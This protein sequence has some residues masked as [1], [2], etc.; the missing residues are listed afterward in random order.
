MWDFGDGGNSNSANPSHTYSVSGT[1]TVKLVVIY[2]NST[3]EVSKQIVI[4]Q[5]N[6]VGLTADRNYICRPG[7]ITFTATGKNQAN[8]TWDFGDG[9]SSGSG[10]NPA[11]HSY[12]NFGTYT[13]SLN[14]TDIWGCTASAN[15]VID[16]K[17]PDVSG[18]V[19]ATSGCIPY[20]TS[21]TANATIPVNSTVATYAWDFGDGNTSATTVNS[22]NHT[23]TVRGS[24]TPQLT[25]TTSEG[26]TANFI[27]PNVAFGTAPSSI[28]AYPVNDS[29]CAS[30][31]AVLIAKSPNANM[32]IWQF[33]DGTTASTGDTLISHKY[34]SLGPKTITVR[35]YD[36]GCGSAPSSFNV[37]VIGVIAEYSYNINCSSRSKVYFTNNST[38]NI[39]SFLW[40]YGDGQQND[41][42]SSPIH[43]FPITGSYN[44]SLR[45][46]DSLSGCSDITQTSIYTAIPRLI[47]D[48]TVVCR[49]SRTTFKVENSYA[50]PATLYT[51]HIPGTVSSPMSGET[52]SYKPQYF[53]TYPVSY[54]E[55]DNGPNYCKDTAYL[56]HSILVYGP[57]LNFTIDSSICI[58]D[59]LS[60]NNLSIPYR[61]QDSINSWLWNIQ[62][63]SIKAFQPSPQVFSATGV[64]SVVLYATDIN[65]CTDS[66][67]KQVVINGLPFLRLVPARDTLCAGVVDTLIAFHIDPLTWSSNA[68]IPCVNCDT[69]AVAPASDAFYAAQV[70]S[71]AGCVSRDTI[72]IRVYEPFNAL[73]LNPV[74]YICPGDTVSLNVAPAGMTIRWVPASGIQNANAYD[75]VVAPI[76]TTQYRALLYDSVGCYSDSALFTL[77]VKAPAIVDAGPDTIVAYN[78]SITINPQ[79]SNNIVQYLWSPR[80]DLQCVNCSDPYMV[81]RDNY[82]YLIQ[83]TSDSGCVATDSISVFIRC[84]DASLLLPNAFTPNDDNLN[85]VFF[86]TGRGLGLIK[87]FMVYD[88]FGKLVFVKSNFRANDPNYGWDGRINGEPASPAV[89]VYF[90]EAYCAKGSL[91]MKKGTVTLLK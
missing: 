63:N 11:T 58:Y 31:D 74:S 37:E 49:N 48:D 70:T 52:L 16:V 72:P 89:Y 33:G 91:I 38:G 27:Y 7:N 44:T 69:I 1:Y 59:S 84:D 65:G 22:T 45:V 60:I 90:I 4:H 76:Q 46:V 30:N 86:P 14:V 39:S 28:N 68:A 47:N 64:Q 29:I 18:T 20:G 88:R 23:Y 81:A 78:S 75:P 51:Y 73:A 32:Y 67:V 15:T 57:S 9:S 53:G 55:I 40:D 19:S 35:A 66:L 10:G 25:I 41:S 56:N 80:G 21:F 50:N 8:Y 12:G 42:V 82:T 62:S 79:Y 87:R 34:N 6:A 83:V 71:S 5:P 2:T 24:Y 3:A 36:N 26:C 13:V 85:D 77:N 61:S 43:S 54:V 17:K